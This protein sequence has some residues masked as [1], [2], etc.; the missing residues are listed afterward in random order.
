MNLFK[1]L[2]RK[3]ALEKER[4]A[5]EQRQIMLQKVIGNHQIRMRELFA[6]LMK[7]VVIPLGPN[8]SP[9]VPDIDIRVMGKIKKLIALSGEAD[10]KDYSNEFIFML[11]DY[12][13][14]LAKKYS[15]TTVELKELVSKQTEAE[16]AADCC[17]CS[18]P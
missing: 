14:A 11:A 10:L 18:P 6:M 15:K 1:L 13:D 16:E 8:D 9:V 3:K 2:F 5:E 4:I 17:E 7:D 12:E